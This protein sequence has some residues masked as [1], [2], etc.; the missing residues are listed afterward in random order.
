MDRD[1]MQAVPL[2]AIL[3]HSQIPVDVYICISEDKYLLISKAGSD[4]KSLAK[5]KDRDV[6]SMYVKIRD[7]LH[8]IQIA[9][10]RAN[11]T[12]TG[13]GETL[14]KVKS[15]KGAMDSVYREIHDLGFDDSVFTHVKM[16][17]HSTLTLLAKSP[18]LIDMMA[19]LE[20]LE[21]DGVKHAMM[22]S[23]TSAMLGVAQ[24]WT[25]P[26]TIEKLALAG[27]LHDVGKTKLPREVVE[28]PLGEMNEDEL[29]IYRSHPEVGA[30]LLMQSK[31]IPE[32]VL[33]AVQEHHECADGS[34]FPRAIKDMVTSPFARVVSVASS[35]VEC[36]ESGQFDAHEDK[37]RAVVDFLSFTQAGKY[38]RDV[39]VALQRLFPKEKGRAAG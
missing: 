12:M 11:S 4:V 30:L 22:V 14:E 9:L 37:S 16:V 33:L 27:F 23:L 39:L 25:K 21:G 32:D 38:N 36:L 28:K 10:S 13:N 8:L 15:L 2:D 24:G 7:Y 6:H 1:Q 18:R 31:Q 3:S 34:G 20:Q 19:E 26:G 17:N 5:Y 35:F 29:I